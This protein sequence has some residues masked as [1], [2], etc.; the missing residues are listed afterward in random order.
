MLVKKLIIFFV[1]HCSNCRKS[2]FVIFGPLL[3]EMGN[4][5]FKENNFISLPNFKDFSG[6]L[7]IMFYV[8]SHLF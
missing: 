2:R 4:D 5:K 8:L 6:P 7:E 3:Q 1:I